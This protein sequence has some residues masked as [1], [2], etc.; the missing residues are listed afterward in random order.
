LHHSRH[1]LPLCILC[2][3]PRCLCRLS[4]S[5]LHMRSLLNHRQLCT[6]RLYHS[7]RRP[8]PCILQQKQTHLVRI[9]N[10][11]GT[12]SSKARLRY[13]TGFAKTRNTYQGRFYVRLQLRTGPNC[14]I[15]HHCGPCSRNLLDTGA[16]KEA[17]SR[18]VNESEMSQAVVAK[19]YTKKYQRLCSH[20]Q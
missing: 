12:G 13:S 6:Y 8:P 19:G 9:P 14:Y 10:I 15:I 3:H 17:H 1:C 5:H 4:K 16:C 18:E 2:T 7:L 20:S 11:I